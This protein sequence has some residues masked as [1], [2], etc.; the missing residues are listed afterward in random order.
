MGV[1]GALILISEQDVAG[2]LC[3]GP[4]NWDLGGTQEK[5]EVDKAANV[6]CANQRASSPDGSTSFSCTAF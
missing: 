4:C 5:S 2:F 3:E 6:V 1:P